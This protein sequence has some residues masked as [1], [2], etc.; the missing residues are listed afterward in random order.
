MSKRI[1]PALLVLALVCFLLPWVSVSCQG[2]KLASFTGLQLATGTSIHTPEMFGPSQT[3]EFQRETLAI[4]TLLSVLIAA[5]AAIVKGK[6]GLQVAAGAGGAAVLFQLLLKAKLDSDLTREGQGLLQ[7]EYQFG[8]WI[9]ML[10]SASAAVMAV[11]SLLSHQSPTRASAAAF[12][13]AALCAKCGASMPSSEV[14]CSQ[15][16]EKLAPGRSDV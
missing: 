13:P 15:C 3:R 16:G 1:S 10:M 9:V 12:G 8:F 14:F 7:L 4:L 2:Q 11:Y 6:A 5:V